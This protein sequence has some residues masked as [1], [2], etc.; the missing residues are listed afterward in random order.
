[1]FASVVTFQLS[2]DVGIVTIFGGRLDE[3]RKAE[4]RKNYSVVE[5]GYNSFPNS[6]PGTLHYK[7]MQ[8]STHATAFTQPIQ[9]ITRTVRLGQRAVRMHVTKSLDTVPY[10]HRRRGGGC[11]ACCATSCGSVVARPG[12]AP[13]CWAA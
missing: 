9:R 4:L 6:L 2:F 10:V 7:A 3:R 11:T 5:K 12:R 8:V 13:A 1:M